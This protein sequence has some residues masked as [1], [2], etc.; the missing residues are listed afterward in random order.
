[1][2]AGFAF[3]AFIASAN[4]FQRLTAPAGTLSTSGSPYR[5]AATMALDV[6][7]RMYRSSPWA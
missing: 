5:E 6:P 2:A 1:V 4:A 7:A 3:V